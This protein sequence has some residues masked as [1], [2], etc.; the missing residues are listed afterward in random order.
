[1]RAA[2]ARD[3]VDGRSAPRGDAD[4]VA[5]TASGNNSTASTIPAASSPLRRGAAP[6]SQSKSRFGDGGTALSVLCSQ[7]TD[8][9]HDLMAIDA[10]D[11]AAAARPTDQR[12]LAE[13]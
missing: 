10:G 6:V 2:G 12:L 9:T 4:P 3:Q 11:H 13:W 1:L 5:S 7:R 8:R